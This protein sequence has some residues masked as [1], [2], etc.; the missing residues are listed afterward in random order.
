MKLGCGKSAEIGTGGRER[1]HPKPYLG[2]FVYCCVADR[3]RHSVMLRCR[4]Y[5]HAVAQLRSGFASECGARPHIFLPQTPQIQKFGLLHV[6]IL[7]LH[8]TFVTKIYVRIILQRAINLWH[9]WFVRF[10]SDNIVPFESSQFYLCRSSVPVSKYRPSLFSLTDALSSRFLPLLNPSADFFLRLQFAL[11]PSLPSIRHPSLYCAPSHHHP[12][13]IISS[14]PSAVRLMFSLFTNLHDRFH[15]TDAGL[16]ILQLPRIPHQH[17]KSIHLLLPS[18][19][20]PGLLEITETSVRI[21]WTQVSKTS[22]R[23]RPI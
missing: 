2:L 3:S 22:T 7:L 8:I 12:Y 13:F 4:F 20:S 23:R 11:P 15:A 16:L 10:V 19:E 6:S 5:I 17:L 1:T 21:N 18:K 14:D 9:R